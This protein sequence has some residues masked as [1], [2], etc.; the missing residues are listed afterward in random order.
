MFGILNTEEIEILLRQQFIGR[1]GCH[2]D[3]VTYIVPIS[4]AYDGKNIFAHTQEGMKVSIMRKN[5]NV[6]FEVDY[7]EDIQHWRSVICWGTC[8][9]LVKPEER[10]EALIKL[11]ARAIPKSASATAKL[12]PEWPFLPRDI[13]SIE[14]VVFRIH[15]HKKTGKYEK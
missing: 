2:S 12:S 1:I 11:H 8:I 9:E 3:S 5:T 4:Y 7:L 6:C 10:E 15:L 14:G 13:N